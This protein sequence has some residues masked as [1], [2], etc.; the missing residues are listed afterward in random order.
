MRSNQRPPAELGYEEGP[1]KVPGPPLLLVADSQLTFSDDCGSKI[2]VLKS[3]RNIV[4]TII[5]V[6]DALVKE[7]AEIKADYPVSYADAL[8]I[9]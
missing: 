9:D 7:A 1:S 6:D 2:Q 5:S 4:G 8:K 3:A